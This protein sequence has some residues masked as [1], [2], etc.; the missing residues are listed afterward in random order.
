[1][2]ALVLFNLASGFYL[3]GVA[4]H[5]YKKNES[6]SLFVEKL[7]SSVTQIPYEYYY[8]NFCPPSDFGR[9]KENI[10]QELVGDIIEK[11]PYS[12][13]MQKEYN[14]KLLCNQTNEPGHVR[15]FK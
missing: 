10:G 5:D 7:D 15:D 3:P 6:I 1:M 9:E 11:S 13:F 14:C 2:L 8:L 4:P 12:I